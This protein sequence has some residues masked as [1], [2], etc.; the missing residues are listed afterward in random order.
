VMIPV[1]RAYL[2][3]SKVVGE[4]G[5]VNCPTAMNDPMRRT[6]PQLD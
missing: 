4:R 5:T 3:A 2:A 1:G 6:F